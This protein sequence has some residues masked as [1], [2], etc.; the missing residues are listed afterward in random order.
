VGQ[1]AILRRDCQSR[2]AHVVANVRADRLS[3]CRLT[4]RPTQQKGLRL[5]RPETKKGPVSG[6]FVI[7]VLAALPYF[8]FFGAAFF[9]AAFLVAFFID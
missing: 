4:T 9:L 7:D 3:A 5:R 1:D 2:L 8:F 6:A